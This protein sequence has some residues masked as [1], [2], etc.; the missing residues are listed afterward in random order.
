MFA[1]QHLK[2]RRDQVST[3]LRELTGGGGLGFISL[4]SLNFPPPQ[5]GCYI[6]FVLSVIQKNGGFNREHRAQTLP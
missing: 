5:K 3:A 4:W 1:Y 2:F 6:I